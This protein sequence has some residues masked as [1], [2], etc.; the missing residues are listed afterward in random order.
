MRLVIGGAYQGKLKFSIS[1]LE[2]ENIL[3][4][5]NPSEDENTIDDGNRLKNENKANIR[6]Q[7]ADGRTD[8]YEEAFRRPIVA[9]FH[10]YIRRLLLE[11]KDPKA[12]AE[13][14]LEKNKR[15]VIVADEIGY[16]IVP[17]DPFERTYREEDG[18]VCQYLAAEAETVYRVVCGL[19]VRIKG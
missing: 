17:V 7:W 8:S 6:K 2:N 4:N 12:F 19:A 5:K 15:A 10:E 11:G 1:L 13:Q 18:R 9:C 3:K 16:G 14:L